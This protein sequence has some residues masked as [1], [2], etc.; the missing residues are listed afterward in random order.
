MTQAPATR[1]DPPALFTSFVVILLIG[2][3]AGWLWGLWYQGANLKLFPSRGA[4]FLLNIGWLVCLGGVFW[5]LLE[6]WLEW[7]FL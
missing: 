6:F 5:V 1:E 3:F 2:L 4:G 7:T